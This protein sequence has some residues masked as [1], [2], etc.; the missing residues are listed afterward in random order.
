MP[1]APQPSEPPAA[2]V[3]IERAREWLR[4]VEYGVSPNTIAEREGVSRSQVFHWL[5]VAREHAADAA[6]AN[7]VTVP[8][9]RPVPKEPPRRL[10]S[11]TLLYRAWLAMNLVKVFRGLTDALLN[12]WRDA[13]MEIS[14]AGDGIALTWGGPDDLY[15]SREHFLACMRRT[16]ADLAEL[17]DG[18]L[19]IDLEGAGIA[20]PYRFGLRP[21]EPVGGGQR[22]PDRRQTSMLYAV[23]GGR[24]ESGSSPDSVSKTGLETGLAAGLRPDESGAAAGLIAGLQAEESGSP[25]GLGPDS[26]SRARAPSPSLSSLSSYFTDSDGEKEE[27]GRGGRGCAR[28]RARV[29]RCGRRAGLRPGL[30]KRRNRRNS[31][32]FRTSRVRPRVR[33][34]FRYASAH[35]DPAAA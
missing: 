18:H 21:K 30:A 17:L 15:R 1:R 9:G 13:V 25:A 31:A 10:S 33:S 19:L 4:L 26:A 32:K 35:Q 7:A 5:K 27:E 23:Q 28:G 6:P 20:L 2:T 34:P 22:Q 8:A 29:R 11:R 12:F 3:T 16:G 14:E 24:A